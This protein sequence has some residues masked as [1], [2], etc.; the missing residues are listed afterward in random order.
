[1]SM[2]VDPP[3]GTSSELVEEI[4]TRQEFAEAL[5]LL[6]ENAGLTVRK[7][8]DAVDV[9]AST[10][11]GYFSGRHVPPVSQPRLLTD[12]LR[13]CGVEDAKTVRRWRLALSQVRRA[14]G[15]RPTG[16]R[17]PYRGLASFQPEDGEWFFGRDELS[18]AVVA[19]LRM[20][21]VTGDGPVVVSGPSGSGKS[22][23]LRAGVIPALRDGRLGADGSGEWPVLL[24]TPGPRPVEALATT[25]AELA[26]TDPA[27]IAAEM[28]EWPESSAHHA[29]LAAGG[30]GVTGLHV[31]VDQLEEV[32][33]QAAD[34]EERRVFLTA[35]DAMARSGTAGAETT[36]SNG[37]RPDG[38]KPAAAVALGLRADFYHRALREPQLL[39]VLQ[40]SQVVVGPMAE[41]DL[42]AAI[43]E[44]ARMAGIEIED[45]LVGMILRDLAPAMQ[46]D[47]QSAHETGALPLL[48]HALLATWERSPAGRLTLDAYTDAGAIR[49][50]VA[51]TADSVIDSLTQ[52]QQEVARQILVRLVRIG[53][54]EP[55][56]RRRM[57][58][59]EL[60]P[61]RWA[62][63]T[64]EELSHVVDRLSESRLVTVD[65]DTVEIT[66]ESILAAWPRLRSWVEAD[67]QELRIRQQLD[68]AAEHWHRED[69]DPA[70]LYRG[71][72][73]ATAREVGGRARPG[74]LA[75]E[76]LEASMSRERRRARTLYSV[77]AC[78]VV[79]LLVAIAG[80]TY[81]YDLRGEAVAAHAVAAEERNVALSRIVAIR[82][83]RLRQTDPA[84]AQQLAA[85]AYQTAPTV[86]ARSSLLSS[87][88]GPALTR[89]LG[90]DGIVQS[91]AVGSGGYLAAAAGADG[92][93]RLWDLGDS[94]AP[95]ELADSLPGL[96][97]VVNELSL[98]SDGGL[99]A[100]AGSDQAV[101]LYDVSDTPSLLAKTTDSSGDLNAV[102]LSPNRSLLAA[103][104]LDESVWLWNVTNPEAPELL[105]GPLTAPD[106]SVTA[107]TF[108]PDGRFLVAGGYDRT[109][110]IW[111][112][113]NPAA[114][115]LVGEALTGPELAVFDIEF[116]P[117]GEV[118]AAAS[119]DRTVH[120][121]D[122]SNPVQPEALDPLTG[123]ASWVNSVTFSPDGQ[124]VAAGSSDGLLW[125]WDR[126][127][128]SEIT[129]LPHAGPVTDA[130][131][132]A[133]GRDVFTSAADGV[134]RRWQLPG[135]VLAGA[136]DAVHEVA[137][138]PARSVVAVASGDGG[139][140]LWDVADWQRPTM[141]GEPV[142]SPEDD[143]SHLVGA[144]A[145]SPDGDTMV[146]AGLDG[147]VWRWDVT[148]LEA[149]EPIGPPLEGLTTYAERLT[150]SPDGDLLA[151][152]AADG[153]IALW[154]V[155]DR[156]QPELLGTLTD[157]DLNVLA[158]TFSPDGNTLA[159]GGGDS[160]VWVWD[161]SDA[162]EPDLLT[163]PLTGPTNSVY[164]LSFDPS[165]NTLAVGSADG[166]VRLWDMTDVDEPEEGAVLTGPE[167]FVVG[168]AFS[169]DGD[170]LAAASTDHALWVW[171][172]AD[173][174]EPSLYATLAG[175]DDGLHAVSF[176]HSGK[177]LVAAGQDPTGRIWQADPADAMTRVCDTAG[178][179]ITEIEWTEHAPGLPYKP[180]C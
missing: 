11:G 13:V 156:D 98:Q 31:V 95:T 51:S 65:V 158:I 109:V 64:E 57:K 19:R 44:P 173:R 144:A 34:G 138:H 117:D 177:L 63:V 136:T 116:S 54:G 120:L 15:P 131:F 145:F 134:V 143:E 113:A 150:F 77:I 155:T 130:V 123:P 55:H 69:R 76:F 86:E 179:P 5:T 49:G 126:A 73:L 140:Y 148:D 23:L 2:S 40:N 45:G 47:G 168:L 33:T 18:L 41:A 36:G 132:D 62:G 93:V 101:Y 32:F 70:M 21:W 52:G 39:R 7:V 159:A 71:S 129:T 127:T 161:V 26:G 108:S 176:D 151:A 88:S 29:R 96:E 153:T 102:A 28:R 110:H 147:Q 85:A 81:V 4:R 164:W 175:A 133:A 104:G 16:A 58:W 80:G 20:R 106:D 3:S 72:R 43:V 10:L 90:P 1:M 78:L 46:L 149:P 171:D 107:V 94:N 111:D 24:F 139:V 66:H 42:R 169:P 25:L 128:G 141:L 174:D 17:P 38:E 48:S 170:R 56:T 9:P 14:P 74:A 118:L 162:S 178:D 103:G 89:M 87:S 124:T 157:P 152:G 163:D 91:I 79:L 180:P 146:S 125:L 84:L 82:S 6:R 22:S 167:G 27:E 97:G 121:W 12:I 50:S 99:L 166:T 59:D 30:A 135:P 67:R 112:I 68:D 61:S 100:A 8:A 53:D 75:T 165:G 122:V 154:D 137:Y 142:R 119:E 35:V 172:V 60:E 37:S 92:S 105:A 115:D 83:D 160:V 114:P